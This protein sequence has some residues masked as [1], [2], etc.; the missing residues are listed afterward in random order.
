MTDPTIRTPA[1]GF[2]GKPP[3]VMLGTVGVGAHGAL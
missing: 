2:L 3:S 1:A